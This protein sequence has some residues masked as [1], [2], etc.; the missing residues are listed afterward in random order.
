MS[1]KDKLVA[2]RTSIYADPSLHLLLNQEEKAT[3]GL[4]DPSRPRP[5][6]EEREKARKQEA[7]QA[8]YNA[9]KAKQAG[10]NLP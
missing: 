10:Y 2:I 4:L 8:Q 7:K 5:P 3:L 9:R 1:L 6:P